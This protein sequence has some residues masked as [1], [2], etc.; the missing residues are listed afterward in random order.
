MLKRRNVFLLNAIFALILSMSL[1]SCAKKTVQREEA[2]APPEEIKPSETVTSPAVTPPP[3]PMPGPVEEN[4]FQAQRQRK[5]EEAV[6]ANEDIHFDFDRY[7]LKPKAREI[8][9]DK[10][11]FLR[12]Y[13]GVKILIEGHCDERGT[14]EYNLALGE[15][16][17]N[18]AKQYLVQLGISEGRIS[19]VSYGEERPLDPGHNEEAWARN[20][21]AH[22]EI[23]SR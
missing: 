23:V 21:R 3:K 4:L 13:P 5:K 6:F 15:R 20:R 18:S 9:S 19:T 2:V 14:N 10:A 22:F 11:F 17:A 1:L 12:K 7:D 8:L 16:R